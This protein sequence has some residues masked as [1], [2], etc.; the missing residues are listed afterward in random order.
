MPMMPKSCARDACD[1]LARRG[2][3]TSTRCESSVM[4]GVW[5]GNSTAVGSCTG[6]NVVG[7]LVKL[8]S[9]F[10]EPIVPVK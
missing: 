8:W 1:E 9:I 2:S 10:C 6:L 7:P 3:A 4:V 5:T